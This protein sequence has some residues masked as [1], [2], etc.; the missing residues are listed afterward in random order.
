MSNYKS[1]R[2]TGF[3]ELQNFQTVLRSRTLSR[4]QS[5]SLLIRQFRVRKSRLPRAIDN[6]I[7]PKFKKTHKSTHIKF[8]SQFEYAKIIII[9]SARVIKNGTRNS[10]DCPLEQTSALTS[11]VPFRPP[12][13][14][15]AQNTIVC[16][17]WVLK[18]S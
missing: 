17:C 14:L 15:V 3:F 10:C 4:A 2:I 5:S 1:D 11:F 8:F 12:L 6:K 9:I 16:F 7:T 18:I 13:A